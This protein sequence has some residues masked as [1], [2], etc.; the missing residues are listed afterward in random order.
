[1]GT[2]SG[3]IK[4]GFV[5]RVDFTV[6]LADG[7][8]TISWFSAQPQPSTA[9]IAAASVQ[10]D[11]DQAAEDARVT[12]LRADATR[13]A[14]LQRLKSATP[15]QISDYVENQ[16]TGTTAQQVIAVKAILKGILLA[17]ALDQRQ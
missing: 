5:P 12:G 9:A 17:I 3:L 10:A 13:L 4:L 2:A 1:M 15:T 7:V 6:S 8:E 11:Q 14:L 16:V